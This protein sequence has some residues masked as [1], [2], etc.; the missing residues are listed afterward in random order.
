MADP[1]P[2]KPSTLKQS[3]RTRPAAFAVKICAA[4]QG[5]FVEC[6]NKPSFRQKPMRLKTATPKI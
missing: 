1:F 4:G 6:L 2:A 5:S 3:A